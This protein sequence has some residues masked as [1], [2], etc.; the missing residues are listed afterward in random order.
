MRLGHPAG[1]ERL[2]AA[3]E[4]HLERTRR[5][6][7]AVREAAAHSGSVAQWAFPDLALRWSERQHL[8][9]Q[10]PARALLADQD[11]VEAAAE[12]ARQAVGDAPTPG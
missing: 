9:E 6:L 10:A 4:G 12:A 5:E 2:R 7:A 3:L 1:P 11:E 8:A